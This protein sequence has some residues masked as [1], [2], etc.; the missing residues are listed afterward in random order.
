MVYSFSPFMSL[1]IC[2]NLEI[3]VVNTYAEI[4][5][6]FRLLNNVHTNNMS[7]Y[8][9]NNALYS[10]TPINIFNNIQKYCILWILLCHDIISHCTY[11]FRMEFWYNHF[12]YRSFTWVLLIGVYLYYKLLGN[13]CIKSSPHLRYFYYFYS[14][15]YILIWAVAIF[16][17]KISGIVQ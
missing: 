1:H 8:Y 10:E 16:D 2:V 15:L 4:I 12:N 11:L 17:Y 13:T 7:V 5:D 3:S 6:R 14:N 9:A